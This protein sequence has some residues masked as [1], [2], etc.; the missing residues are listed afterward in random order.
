MSGQALP[1]A[2][3]FPEE[4]LNTCGR[5]EPDGSSGKILTF[6]LEGFGSNVERDASDIELFL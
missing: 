2:L 6:N 3:R 5:L 4:Q 1:V